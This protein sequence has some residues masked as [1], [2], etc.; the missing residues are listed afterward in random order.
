MAK[1][2]SKKTKK[3][4][5]IVE[6]SFVFDINARVKLENG[7]A[8]TVSAIIWQGGE[9]LYAVQHWDMQGWVV[10]TRFKAHQLRAYEDE[11]TQSETGEAGKA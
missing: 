7:T 3:G 11:D 1:T 6:M 4:R 5:Q 10:T 8:G 2:D 9:P